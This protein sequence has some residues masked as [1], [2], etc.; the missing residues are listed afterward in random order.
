M[1]SLFLLV[2]IAGKRVALPASSVES[3]V[4]IG[5]IEPVPLASAHVAGLFALRS[6]VMTVIDSTAAVGAGRYETVSGRPAVIVNSDGHGY[7]VLVEVVED[8]VNCEAPLT[9]CC[10]LPAPGWARAALGTIEHD[11]EVLLVIDPALLV[12]TPETVAA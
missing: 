9:P 11:D 7:A 8:V 6:R 1:N 4:E 10:A 12:A 2:S 3:V 5:H